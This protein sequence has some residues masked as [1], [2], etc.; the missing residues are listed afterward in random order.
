MNLDCYATLV[1]EAIGEVRKLGAEPVLVI[2]PV[3]ELPLEALG[4]A[5]KYLATRHGVA[6]VD[7]RPSYGG[8]SSGC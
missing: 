2:L 8:M 1:G 3:P 7:L 6:L 5:L 4:T